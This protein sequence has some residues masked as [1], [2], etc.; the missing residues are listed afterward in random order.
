MLWLFRRMLP[1]GIY[2]FNNPSQSQVDGVATWCGHPDA[3]V[4]IRWPK[5]GSPAPH[6]IHHFQ[7][8]ICSM[9]R[10][11][12]GL[13][14]S[15]YVTLHTVLLGEVNQ[16]RASQPYAGVH[17]AHRPSGYDATREESEGEFLEIVWYDIWLVRLI[18]PFFF[19]TSRVFISCEITQITDKHG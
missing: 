2:H 10:A 11:W 17:T 15:R 8:P 7:N 18:F 6:H 4:S 5:G 12:D 16:Q 1:T 19:P 13:I 14:K 9:E 3:Y